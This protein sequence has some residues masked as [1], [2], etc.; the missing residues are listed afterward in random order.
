MKILRNFQKTDVN[1]TY[2]PLGVNSDLKLVVYAD[3][4]HANLSDGGSQEGY[5]IFLVDENNKC[6]LI[7]GQS[8]H[9][10]RVVCSSLSAETLALCDAS[11]DA[12]F[13]QH[14][15]L[16]LLFNNSVKIP[17]NVYTDTL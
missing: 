14:M 5:H 13:L 15:I 10:K 16:E 2:Q 9:I 1:I 8:K 6:S 3:A 11:D 17:I 7:N 12:I 4:A